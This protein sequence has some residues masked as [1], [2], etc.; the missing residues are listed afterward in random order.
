MATGNGNPNVSPE[1]TE[2][3]LGLQRQRALNLLMAAV[4]DLGDDLSVS[5]RV[6][7][8]SD[9]LSE[10]VRGDMALIPGPVAT[11]GPSEPY[12]LRCA[13]IGH[14]LADT[15]G[16]PAG[17]T[18]Y[19]TP[20]ELD[21]DLAVM[22]AS[23]RSNG[24]AL[25]AD[26]HLSRVRRTLAAVGFHMATLDV[27]EHTD[28]HHET[29]ARL[30]SAVGVDYAKATAA[31]R[32]DILAAELESRRPLAPP[33]QEDSGDALALFRTL[34]SI[35]DRDGDEV[36]ESYIVSMTRGVDDVLAPVLSG[37]RGGSCRPWP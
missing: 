23:L 32:T 19:G 25:L 1:M 17:P 31:E 15:A 21:E 26:G 4:V 5:T 6:Q 34:R 8:V 18:A 28:R 11:H 24:G 9:E 36:I 30:F 14:R 3:V 10:A 7:G 27:R 16:T 29:L 2:A 33:H 20:A 13:A 22:D 35:L 37:P 12:R